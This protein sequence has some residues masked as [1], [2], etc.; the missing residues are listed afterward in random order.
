MDTSPPKEESPGVGCQAVHRGENR[1]SSTNA[2]ASI[3]QRPGRGNKNSSKN[4]LLLRGF[5]I[6]SR[7]V[8]HKL[9]VYC[10]TCDQLH[11]HGWLDAYGFREQVVEAGCGD[12]NPFV[13]HYR[14]APFKQSYLNQLADGAE[15]TT[16]L[17]LYLSLA[18]AARDQR[19]KFLAAKKEVNH[20]G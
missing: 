8:G 10:P 20:A 16:H 5:L 7:I 2:A 13:K 1:V 3:A 12:N 4:L 6:G 18:E 15:G 9:Y 11:T 14:V 17:S 19:A